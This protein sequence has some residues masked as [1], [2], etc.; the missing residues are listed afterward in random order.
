M[1]SGPC[2]GQTGAARRLQHEYGNSAY[3]IVASFANGAGTSFTVSSPRIGRDSLLPGAGVAVLLSDRI[4]TYIYYDGELG[5][6]NYQ[7]NSVS[8]GVRVTF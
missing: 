6:T 2:S 1:E 4:S 3:S 5:R 7:S 8:G